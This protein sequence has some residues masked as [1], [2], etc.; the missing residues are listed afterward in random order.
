M[1][2]VLQS[3]GGGSV[4][5]AEPT[6]ASDFTQTL[7]AV[8]GTVITTGNIPAGSVLQVVQTVK[9][10]TASTSSSSWS[11]ITGMSV[12]ITPA[13]SSNKI[14]VFA[15]IN[16]GTNFSSGF[17]F[18][19]L[20]RESTDIYVGDAAGSRTRITTGSAS[21][22]VSNTNHCGIN[23][24]DSPATTSSTTYKIQW[25]NQNP[26]FTSYL[27]RTFSDTDDPALSR[28]PSSITVMEIA[29]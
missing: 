3:S 26:S 9:T 19:K 1:S 13:S 4:T 7:P 22:G 14:L 21:S 29:G 8:D 10:D 20:V 12:S 15:D 25:Y 5:I 11:D 23:Y 27:N 6:T 16:F 28:N 17:I 18:F 2:L 24:L